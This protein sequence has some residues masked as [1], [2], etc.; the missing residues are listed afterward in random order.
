MN[1][2]QLRQWLERALAAQRAG[3]LADAA[4]LYAR[5]CAA[6]PAQFDAFHLAGRLALQRGRPAESA[7]LLGRAARLH[8]R[9]APCLVRLAHALKALGRPAEAREAAAAAAD[10]DPALADAHFCLG[11][12]AAALDGFGAA[13]PHFRRVTALE[14]AAADGWANLG[15]ALAQSGG[16]AEAP[17]AF[18]RALACDPANAQALTGRALLLQETHR[19]TEAAAAYAAVLARHPGRHDARSGR[20]LVLHYVDGISREELHAEHRAFGAAL[21]RLPAPALPNLPDPHRRLRVAFLSPDLRAHSVAYFL[22]PLLAHLDPAAFEI[23]LYHDH[24]RVDAVSARLRRHAAQWRH[25]AGLPAARV[26]AAIRADAPDLLVDL[27]GHTGFNRLPLFARRLAPVQATY[28]GY[29]DTTGLAAMDYRLTDAIADP[30]GAEA[31]HTEKLV[32]FASAAWAYAP[33]A[34]APEPAPPPCATGAAVTFGC[35]NNPAKLGDA[36]L[37]AWAALL[38]AVPGARLLLKGRGL[39]RPDAAAALR[40][41]LARAGAAPDRIELLGRIPGLRS[42]LG[43][44]ARVDVALDPFPYHGTTTTCEALWMGRPVVTLAGDRHAARVGASLLGAAGHPE[45]V[46]RDWAEY[47]ALAAGLVRDPAALERAAGGLRGDLARSV[48]L[49]HA[50]Q[51]ARFGAALRAG[52]SAWCAGA[53]LPAAREAD[54]A[55]AGAAPAPNLSP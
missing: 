35:F 5:A 54:L 21:G 9:S 17:E 14:P 7:E 28:L 30:P 39:D 25:F 4:S 20:L 42:H 31:F 12:L 1:P 23:F 19:A 41:R 26:E 27:A 10:Q 53:S 33:P 8:P 6:A 44:Y 18:A 43:L 47:V 2:A 24:P 29:P 37:R 15:V 32:R 3:R 49:D 13:V 16:A 22:E 11:D 51:A 40:D 52:W 36:T 46:A 45:W 48:L 38:A 50:G 55:G 34:E